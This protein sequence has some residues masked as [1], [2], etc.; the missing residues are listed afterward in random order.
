ML[1]KMPTKGRIRR[2]GPLVIPLELKRLVK[3]AY[4]EDLLLP[5]PCL[6][7]C[8]WPSSELKI[9]LRLLLEDNRVHSANNKLTN[10]AGNAFVIE[11]NQ[12]P[13]R[14]MSQSLIR[15]EFLLKIRKLKILK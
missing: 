8:F 11:T 7:Q 3:K 1:S 15:N 10:Y 13:A 14:D 6:S 4:G 2:M 12:A 9:A 5:I